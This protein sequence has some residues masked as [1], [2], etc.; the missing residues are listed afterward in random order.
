M[1]E[2]T[3]RDF[4]LGK[5]PASVL[6]EEVANAAEQ[7]DEIRQN[8]YIR[9]MES[10]FLISREML[11][12]LCDAVLAEQL[13]EAAL[14]TI[15][16]ALMASDRFDWEEDDLLTDVLWDWSAPEINY[17]LTPVN[18]ERCKRWLLGSEPKPERAPL[19]AE[20]APG[21]LIQEMHKI[22]LI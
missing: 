17:P 11:V 15:A 20:A 21:R 9:D 22:K 16:F 13:P 8:I 3:L 7:L 10:D 1:N 12:S 2:S 5:V 19:S 6:A 4:F 18:I 14:Q